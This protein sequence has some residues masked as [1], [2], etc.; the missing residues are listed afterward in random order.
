MSVKIVVTVPEDS[1]DA[2]RAA[3]GTAGAGVI[4]NYIH[5]SFSSKGLG[6]FLPM[7]G[8]QPAIGEVGK[9]EVVAEERIE[10]TCAAETVDAIVA[11]IRTV[12]PY[13]EVVIDVYP[14]QKV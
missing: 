14:L 10:W 12:H 13:E 3:V 1:A 2:L 4:G 7:G 6:R 11:A 5:C 8:A 9:E